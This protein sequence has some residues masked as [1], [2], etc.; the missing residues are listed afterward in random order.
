MKI[1]LVG[2]DFEENLSIR[3]LS[4]ALRAEG[5]E[6]AL[7]PFNSVADMKSVADLAGEAELIGLSMSF[8]SRADEFLELAALIKQ[9]QPDK[10]I[11]AGGHYAS[12][13]ARPLLDNHPELD[14]IVIHEGERTMVEIAAARTGHGSALQKIAGIAYRD[15][16]RVCFTEPRPMLDDLDELPFPDRRGPARLIAG[17]PTAYMMGSRGCFGRC[18]YCCITT[19]H[20]LAPGRQFRQRR[21]EKIAGEMAQLY[22]E[23]GIRQFVFHDDNFLVPSVPANHERIS[24]LAAAFER[25]AIRDI[26]LVIK[27]R[28]ADADRDVLSRLRDMGLLRVFLGIESATQ[29]GLACL[30][31]NQTVQEAGRAL[32][33]CAGLG[34]SAQFTLMTF[35]PDATLRTIRADID[36]MRCY[37]SNPQ[38]FCRTEIYAGTPLEKRMIDEGRAR[39]DYRAM[40]YGIADPAAELACRTAV[41]LFSP[42]CW[43]S[44]SLMERTIGTDH[45]AAVMGH[46]YKGRRVDELRTR[47]SAWLRKS[48]EDTVNRLARLID[49][50]DSCREPGD[51]MFGSAL[52]DLKVDES[53]SLQRLLTEGAG[54]RTE[55]DELSLGMIGIRREPARQRLLQLSRP[56]VA[57]HAAAALL[58]LGMAGVN[59]CRDDHGICEY[60]ARPLEEKGSKADK[61]ETIEVQVPPSNDPGVCEYAA[62]PLEVKFPPRIDFGVCEYAAMPLEVKNKKSAGSDKKAGLPA[63]R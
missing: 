16:A 63:D 12:C 49:I 27:C 8:Q 40:V 20:R 32:E 45:V 26:A 21:P 42:R 24:A 54:L 53:E 50:C 46:F 10:F 23:R 5:Y 17:V 31:R 39:G 38:N 3:Y 61:P 14:L 58:A 62:M 29:E 55:I 59:G 9:R 2:P 6:T 41:G 18:S 51:D 7:A 43:N 57:R 25:H 15:S 35:H 47:A 37:S 60:A 52:N 48:N 44:G 19:L 4:A 34:I 22:H 11:V 13:A 36:F 33:V 1:L 30:E 28:P 56:G